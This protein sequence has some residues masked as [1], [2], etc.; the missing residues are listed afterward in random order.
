M[1]S[2]ALEAAPTLRQIAPTMQHVSYWGLRESPFRHG[3]ATRCFFTSPTHDEALARL[4][5]LAEQHAALG[6]LT[7]DAG[8]GKSFVLEVVA[9]Q[10]RRRGQVASLIHLVGLEPRGF[11]WLVAAGAQANPDPDDDSVAL[12]RR[13][14]DRLQ[15]NRYQE[16]GLVLLLDD[17]DRAPP[18]VRLQVLRLL[19]THPNHRLTVILAA[20]AARLHHL[21]TDLLQL[22]E[23]RV[24]LEPWQP[25]DVREYLQAALRRAGRPEEA[26]V[27]H[28]SAVVR[29]WELAEGNPRRV[30]QLAELALIVGAGQ[31]LAQIDA[32]TIESVSQEL[33]GQPTAVP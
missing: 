1:S 12:W 13:V 6:I 26:D 14:S 18:D 33:A 20:E 30:S 23:L 15:E 21:G 27:F 25:E 22:S 32:E 24:H 3:L 10:L 19:K 5:F 7:G 4:Q 29:L 2:R 16:R 8:S 17:A 31:G 9:R 11:L 28:E